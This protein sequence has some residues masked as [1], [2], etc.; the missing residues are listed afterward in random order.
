MGDSIQNDY[1][2]QPQNFWPGQGVIWWSFSETK[3]A[4]T[5]SVTVQKQSKKQQPQN[6]LF[7]TIFVD[8]NLGGIRAFN[9]VEY[10]SREGTL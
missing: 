10:N 9:E 8:Q 3:M 6:T 7:L 2:K 5:S 4:Q 1:F